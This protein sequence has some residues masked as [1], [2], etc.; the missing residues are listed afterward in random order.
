M[1][2]KLS[3][4]KEAIDAV[5]EKFRSQIGVCFD[6]AHGFGAGEYDL[7]RVSEVKRFF[8]E[9]DTIIGREFLSCFHLND[10]RVEFGCYGDR[11]EMLGEGYQFRT[12]ALEGVE[13]KFDAPEGD[14]SEDEKSKLP[15]VN[16]L[17]GL[18]ILVASAGMR[19]VPLIGEQP[20]LDVAGNVL[21]SPWI[22]DYNIL[23]NM[24]N[25]FEVK[26]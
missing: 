7:G 2:C 12:D 5:N 23:N 6:T 8:E 1:G 21:W 17:K 3:E 19:G 9:F 14:P 22:T 4:I 20:K 25:I 16:G 13:H 11:H 10:S 24:L 15:K 26:D 18:K